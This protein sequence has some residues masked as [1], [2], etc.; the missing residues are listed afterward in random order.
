MVVA[1]AAVVVDVVGKLRCRG[2]VD[3]PR[4]MMVCVLGS[5]V[6]VGASIPN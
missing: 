4:L 6:K 1:S 3:I 5:G 2:T